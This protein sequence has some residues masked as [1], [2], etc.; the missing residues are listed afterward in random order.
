MNLFHGALADSL[1]ADPCCGAL[2]LFTIASAGCAC[3]RALGNWCSFGR[4]RGCPPGGHCGVT[5]GDP[6]HVPACARPAGHE[7]GHHLLR[8]APANPLWGW[9]F[10][11][12]LAQASLVP[13]RRGAILWITNAGCYP[14]P[15]TRATASLQR[16]APDAGLLGAGPALGKFCC[17]HWPVGYRSTVCSCTCC[18]PQRF[19]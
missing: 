16:P 14:K 6:R 13:G 12:R 7:P 19:K 9:L 3:R 8:V 2:P 10:V 11:H 1:A 5:R 15:C 17:W 4:C 18:L